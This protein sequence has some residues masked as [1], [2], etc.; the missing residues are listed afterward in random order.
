MSMLRHVRYVSLIALSI[1]VVCSGCARQRLTEPVGFSKLKITSWP[2]QTKP[3]W[4][5]DTGGMFYWFVTEDRKMIGYEPCCGMYAI[6]LLKESG[7]EL[8]FKVAE[9]HGKPLDLR[10]G[11]PIAKSD[12]VGKRYEAKVQ[13]DQ[14]VAISEVK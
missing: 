2:Y 10:N 6:D 3:R 13:G 12:V 4:L 1:I 14:I 7:S 5:A 9:S 11:K 8:I